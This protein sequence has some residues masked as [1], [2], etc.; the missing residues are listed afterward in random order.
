MIDNLFKS[1]TNRWPYWLVYWP[2]RIEKPLLDLSTHDR[3]KRLLKRCNIDARGG[4]FK[5]L[6]FRSCW[7]YVPRRQAQRAEATL[8]RYGY[9]VAGMN[10]TA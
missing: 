6:L 8:K 3:A 10:L 7:V 2:I 9:Q 5:W 4:S 1:K